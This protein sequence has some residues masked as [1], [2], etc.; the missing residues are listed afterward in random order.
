MEH[1]CF[2]RRNKNQNFYILIVTSMAIEIITGILKHVKLKVKVKKNIK[3]YVI[4]IIVLEISHRLF[5]MDQYH[6]R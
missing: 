5:K 2:N 6:I 1:I 4:S 3:K